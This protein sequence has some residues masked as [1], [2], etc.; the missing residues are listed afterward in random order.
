L[1]ISRLSPNWPF[2]ETT[3]VILDPSSRAMGPVL[4]TQLEDAITGSPLP[5]AQSVLLV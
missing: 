3:V 5:L 1:D 2:A 4:S